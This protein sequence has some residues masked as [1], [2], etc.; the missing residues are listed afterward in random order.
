MGAHNR[1]ESKPLNA[2][3]QRFKLLNIIKHPSYHKPIDMSHDIALLK[4][5]RPAI[6]DR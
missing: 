5:E 2:K 3:E 1:V 6:L 4:L